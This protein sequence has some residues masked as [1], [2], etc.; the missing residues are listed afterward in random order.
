MKKTD[1]AINDALKKF[2]TRVAVQ[3]LKEQK[4]F[5]SEKSADKMIWNNDLAFFIAVLL[6]Q[7]IKAEKAWAIPYHLKQRLGYWSVKKIANTSEKEMIK[8]FNTKPKLHRFPK[9]MALRTIKA[10]NK[11][12]SDF[13]G[14]AK[15]IW[16]GNKTSKEVYGNF[17]SFEG[18]GQK[19]ASMATNI[20]ARDFKI[21]F[22]DKNNIDISYDVHVRRV[23]LRTGLIKRDDKDQV[24]NMARQLNPEYPGL[25]D[26]ATWYIG[27]HYCKSQN[28]LCDEC[29]LKTVC[30]K[31]IF[32]NVKSETKTFFE[33]KKEIDSRTIIKNIDSIYEKFKV[34]NNIRLHCK[35]VA[36][37]I[38][39]I[40]SQTKKNIEVDKNLL[41]AGGLLHDLGNIIKIDF[42]S[43][44]AKQTYSKKQ[45]HELQMVKQEII[46]KY[47]S[48]P[49][50]GTKNM[51]EELNVEKK[52]IFLLERSRWDLIEEVMN[53]RNYETKILAYADY[54]VSPKG[55]VN[56][57]ERL[58][59]LKERYKHFHFKNKIKE[60]QIQ[61][62]NEAYFKIEEQLVKKGLKPELIR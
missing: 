61:K 16:Q 5:T 17:K 1:L 10:C 55:I 46:E 34:P 15:N 38:K 6:D 32:L 36:E 23:F 28:P 52:I 42:K 60:K 37:V 7:N 57:K 29:P 41:I 11:I 58:E 56:L 19:K 13:Q 48:S 18:I 59:D 39:Q 47:G 3:S 33:N 21:R 51:L 12:I 43:D 45:L 54:R 44:L 40:I 30:Q 9:T 24:I 25:I 26:L 27:K 8:L 31:K 14:K 50:E 53:K 20:L 35:T 62:R 2:S 4:Q 22:K 49:D